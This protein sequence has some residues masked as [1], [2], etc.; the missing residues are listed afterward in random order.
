MNHLI[1]CYRTHVLLK[2]HR[3]SPLQA[4]CKDAV[5]T[6]HLPASLPSW[7]PSANHNA[8]LPACARV[9]CSLPATQG[10]RTGQQFT[11]APCTYLKTT[12]LPRAKIQ[13]SGDGLGTKSA[14]CKMVAWADCAISSQVQYPYWR[15]CSTASPLQKV[16]QP[17]LPAMACWSSATC[18]HCP[19]GLACMCTHRNVVTGE[20]QLP[21]VQGDVPGAQRG[22]ARG[23]R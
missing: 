2:A 15:P 11:S 6:R 5:A 22:G 16:N 3:N 9:Q 20:G 19:A 8:P 23:W 7:R 10:D 12:E 14:C 13:L 21:D 1:R 18:A 17:V 4:S